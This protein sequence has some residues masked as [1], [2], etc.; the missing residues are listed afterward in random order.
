MA[1][2]LAHYVLAHIPKAIVF[3]SL[4]TA[5]GFV[6]IGWSAWRLFA[7]HGKR[8]AVPSL[9]DSGAIPILRGLVLLWGFISMP[10]ADNIWR[11]YEAEAD[12]FGINASRQP[13]GLADFML[14]DADDA[15][16]DPS[17]IQERLFYG[18]APRS[19]GSSG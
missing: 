15:N 4:I 11:E 10:I 7:R 17:P 14:H 13:L 6:L 1:Q 18:S 2:E 3:D 5:I 16:L 19:T 9:R 8:R 12:I